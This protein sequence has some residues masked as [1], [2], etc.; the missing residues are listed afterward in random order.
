MSLEPTDTDA[1]PAWDD[2]ED[3]S[4]ALQYE[5]VSASL[6][7]PLAH[8]GQRL[9][10]AL[11]ELLPEHSRAR[12]QKWI[13]AGEVR[14]DGA[15]VAPRQRVLGGEQVEVRARAIMTER[16]VAEPMPLNV[17]HEDADILVLNKPAGL[18][19]HP[20]AGN[21]TGTL[22]NGL[23]HAWPEQASVPRAGLV[24]RLDKDTSGLLVVARTA[25]AHSSL[26]R[27]L[28]DRSMGREY[29][30]IVEGVP[31][32]GF[33]VDAPIARD[34]RNRLR[35]AVVPNGRPARTHVRL[36]QRF[37]AHA[38]LHCKLETGRT[39]QIRV[40]LRSRGL[41]LVGDPLYGARQRLAAGASPDLVQAVRNFGRQ[42]LHAA[43]LMLEHPQ[44]GDWMEFEAPLPEEL[45][46]LLEL[47]DA[48]LHADEV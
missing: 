22:V 5:T 17:V 42:A 28:A 15:K 29:L 37:R 4:T 8:S 47:L 48:D 20:G 2:D 7:I 12:L 10:Q 33:T 23:L 46:Q 18:V 3:N 14:V 9:D 36:E 16:W 25:Q 21:L 38:L 24:H 13:R 26:V 45:E 39:H 32:G 44:T 27:Q 35:M 34:P 41:P 31:T 19:V 43:V 1:D 30:A 11:A 6:A 40:H